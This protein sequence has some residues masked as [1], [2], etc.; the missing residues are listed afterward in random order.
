M[1]GGFDDID[2][3]I[4]SRRGR[5]NYPGGFIS[6]SL[7]LEARRSGGGGFGGFGSGGTFGGGGASG[8]W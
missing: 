1:G 4:I 5:K 2:D 7:R 8:S 3:I 6:F